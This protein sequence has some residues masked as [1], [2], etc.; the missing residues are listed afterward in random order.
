MN[1]HEAAVAYYE[2]WSDLAVLPGYPFLPCPICH[3]TEGCDHTGYERAH[4]AHPAFFTPV[5]DQPN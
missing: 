2:G 4:A 1:K 5:N 3:G